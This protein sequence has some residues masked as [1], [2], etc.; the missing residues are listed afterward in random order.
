MNGS[1]CKIDI[2]DTGGQEDYVG[3]KDIYFGGGEG[4]FCVFSI[5][6]QESFAAM[7]DHREQI[8]RVKETE[9]IQMILVGNKADLESRR[10]VSQQEAENLARSWGISYIETSAKTRVNVDEAFTKLLTEIIKFK[11][12]T[13]QQPAKNNKKEKTKCC[14]LL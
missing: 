13:K 5:T 7:N 12:G 1:Q 8:L 9:K 4:F 11:Q 2:L 10:E 6:E 14:V 3:T